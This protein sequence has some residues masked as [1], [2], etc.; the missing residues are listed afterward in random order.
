MRRKLLSFGLIIALLICGLIA[1]AAAEQNMDAD[2]V[3]A[4]AADQFVVL[5]KG[6]KGNEVENIQKRLIQLGYLNDEADGFFDKNTEKAFMDFQSANDL[7]ADGIATPELQALLFGDG[8]LS[9][10]GSLFQAYEWESE[11]IAD[12]KSS[13]GGED[14]AAYIGNK[15]THKFHYPDCNSVDQMKEKNKVPLSSREEAIREGYV[16]CKNCDP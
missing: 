12:V 13:D 15:N 9:A 14:D 4:D 11:P 7:T 8:V 5:E 2:N 6:D 10:S 16:P 3:F 1:P